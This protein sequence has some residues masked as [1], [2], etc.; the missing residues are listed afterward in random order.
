[1]KSQNEKVLNHIRKHGSITPLQ[2]L[3]RYGCFRLAARISNLRDAGNRIK[4]V[5]VTKNGKTFAKY[6]L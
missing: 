1:M 3:S 6:T 2:A 4:T 5:M